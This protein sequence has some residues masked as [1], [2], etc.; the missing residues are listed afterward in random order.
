[1][2]NKPTIMKLQMLNKGYDLRLKDL[3]V[4]D[5]IKQLKTIKVEEKKS[6]KRSSHH[7]GRG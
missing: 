4:L 5:Q 2:G 6:K 3:M 7:T 1:M